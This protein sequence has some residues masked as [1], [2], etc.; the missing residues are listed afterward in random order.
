MATRIPFSLEGEF[1]GLRPASE[2]VRDGKTIPS[3][4]QVRFLVDQDDGDVQLLTVSASALDRVQPPF[5][6]GRLSRGDRVRLRGAAVIQDRG[7]DRDSF[8]VV[9]SAESSSTVKPSAPPKAS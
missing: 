1:V 2:F 5:D 7:S 3:P 9:D 6:Y 4:A 8:F